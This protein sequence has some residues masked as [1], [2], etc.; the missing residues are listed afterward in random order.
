MANS[1]MQLVSDGNL[2]VVPLTIKFF[3]Q[4]HISVYIDDVVL[5]TAGY[6]YAWS[7]ATT[8]T[9][10]PAVA[11]G[12]EVSI[13]RRT[14]A[15]YV[16][17]D[18]QAG[19]VFSEA[20]IDENFL[21][22]LFLLQEAS[23]QSFLTDL[24]SNLNMHG[25][26]VTNLGSPVE[27]T[28]AASVAYV[29]SVAFST[30]VL[31]Y[32]ALRKVM[33]EAGYTLRPYLESFEVGGTLTGPSDVLVHKAT[34]KVYSGL[35]PYPQYVAAG[36]N[37]LIGYALKSNAAL[38][39]DLASDSGAGFV[40]FKR[41]AGVVRNVLAW[42]L[43]QP[44]SVKDYGAKVD[45][46]T[47]DTAA[48]VLAATTAKRIY[49]PD[50]GQPAIVDGL[51]LDAIPGLEVY[52]PGTIK[53]KDGSGTPTLRIQNTTGWYVGKAL[54]LDGNRA[55]R[56]VPVSRNLGAGLSIY[57]CQGYRVR[58]VEVSEVVSGAGILAIDDGAASGDFSKPSSI[59]YCH[60][61]NCGK[62]TSGEGL[63]DGM[64][65]NQ[66]N[67]AAHFNHIHDCT[68]YGIAGDYARNMSIRWNRINNVLVGVG[69]L[70]AK[71][72]DVAFNW[73][74][75]AG[76]GVSV[77]LS[78]NTATDP[79]ISRVVR[80]YGNWIQDITRA[81]SGTPNGDAVFVDPSAVDV[82]IQRNFV[83]GAFRGLA[84][85]SPGTKMVGNRVA[86]C[87]DRGI[88]NSGAGSISRDNT[89]VATAG[90]YYGTTEADKDVKGGGLMSEL[91]ITTLL[92][93]WLT[94]TGS[95]KAPSYYKRD[96]RVYLRG[97]V[98][99]GTQT[100]GVAIFN[101]P[102]GFRP[103]H[104]ARYEVTSENDVKYV[105]QVSPTGD[106]VYRSGTGGTNIQLD[107]ITF[108]VA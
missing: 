74:S 25:N 7:G 57:N 35:G 95:Y 40:W 104:P 16:L 85:S 107:Q 78:G 1:L 68:D 97:A 31:S 6:S 36:T 12:V 54:K 28:D 17:H 48:I 96:G 89:L 79:F 33:Q 73:I 87:T 102:A 11:L 60:V 103:S 43:E 106:V 92:N 82:D 32:E 77:T 67:M 22:D 94:A 65:L 30:P 42:L 10:T 46:V 88:F 20:S 99:P 86:N 52:G 34:G 24:Y 59:K 23:E 50:T 66:D 64:F 44:A 83:D 100:A 27:S 98:N 29:D 9:I 56:A 37:P 5:P 63:A 81:P 15:G 101:L 53:S 47:D 4:S 26:R 21:Q 71:V 69:V 19:A 55:N 45:G 38:R 91:S 76:Q 90:E 2:S 3:E 93:S 39:L 108:P 8:I 105:L 14:P 13:R 58:S 80:I 75:S 72:W 41:V 49:I 61:H 18:F 51:V 84:S 62:A 70:G